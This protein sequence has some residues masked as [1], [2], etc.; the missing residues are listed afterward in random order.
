MPGR[1]RGVIVAP[2]TSDRYLRECED[3]CRRHDIDVAAVTSNPANWW[4]MKDRLAV[5]VLVVPRFMD[6]A[7]FLPPFVRVVESE[8]RAVPAQRRPDRDAK[9]NR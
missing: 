4:I 3:F 8:K 5:D 9:R 1:T 2:V 6:A 7:E